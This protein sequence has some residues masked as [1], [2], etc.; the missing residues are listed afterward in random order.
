MI[1]HAVQP[2]IGVFACLLL[3]G[4]LLAFRPTTPT[5]PPT[6]PSPGPPLSDL[7]PP[8]STPLPDDRAV[9]GMPSEADRQ[10]QRRRTELMTGCIKAKHPLTACL[11]W[12]QVPA[13]GSVRRLWG[14]C[15]Q[16]N[17]RPI[18]GMRDQ[19]C[20]RCQG[21]PEASYVAPN[22]TNTREAQLCR[23]IFTSAV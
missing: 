9:W 5:S 16:R 3:V 22:F 13:T 23:G 11:K 20:R 19:D 17:R 15:H 6:V 1:R 18:Q 7:V 21:K 12:Q 10:E 8:P 2:L 4:G 14:R